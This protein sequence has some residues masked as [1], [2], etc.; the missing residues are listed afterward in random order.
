MTLFLYLL[1][2]AIWGTTWLAIYYQ[3]GNVDIVVSV[4]Y[5]FGLATMIM[6]PLVML[7]RKGR[8]GSRQD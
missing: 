3:L 6:I 8:I 2:V 7:L 4:F 1:T 5:R